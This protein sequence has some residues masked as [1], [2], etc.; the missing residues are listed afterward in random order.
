[1]EPETARHVD[2]LVGGCEDEEAIR[3]AARLERS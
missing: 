2:G 3:R 1:M